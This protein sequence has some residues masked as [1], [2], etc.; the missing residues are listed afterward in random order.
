MGFWLHDGY[1]RGLGYYDYTVYSQLLGEGHDLFD[2]R[3]VT[4]N[5]DQYWATKL[6]Y[7]AVVVNTTLKPGTFSF[8]R[9]LPI[10]E[11]WDSF[12]EAEVRDRGERVQ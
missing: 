4:L 5:S 1:K 9:G 11:A 8:A 10:V 7:A 2:T 6:L 12:I 3:P